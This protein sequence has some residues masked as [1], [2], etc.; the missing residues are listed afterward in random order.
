MSLTDLV[1]RELALLEELDEIRR[2]K[3]ILMAGGSLA[4]PVKAAAKATPST[5]LT[6]PVKAG[7]SGALTAA[8]AAAAPSPPPAPK[9]ITIKRSV[10]AGGAAAAP[11]SSSSVASAA[12]FN[13]EDH[14]RAYKAGKRA[15]MKLADPSLTDT[16]LRTAVRRA[17]TLEHPTEAAAL[18]ALEKEQEEAKRA[19][20]PELNPWLAYVQRVRE[21]G[22]VEADA[23]GKPLMKVDPKTGEESYKYVMTYSEAMGEAS[24]RREAGD[25][26]APPK[27]VKPLSKRAAAALAAAAASDSE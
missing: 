13:V 23:A 5:G 11:S 12:S 25:P 10:T 2:Q 18:T 14:F 17:Y 26:A 7:R 4:K 15:Q 3:E 22:G 9:K 20:P 19:N 16:R 8:A 6:T 1:R 27:A 21:E 24:R